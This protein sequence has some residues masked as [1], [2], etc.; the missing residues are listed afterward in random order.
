MGLVRVTDPAP[1]VPWPRTAVVPVERPVFACQ[2]RQLGSWRLPV[3]AGEGLVR[4][5]CLEREAGQPV[6]GD[7]QA[8]ALVFRPVIDIDGGTVRRGIVRGRDGAM[9]GCGRF[10]ARL[11]LK[12][13]RGGGQRPDR[14]P[15]L[16]V[17]LVDASRLSSSS[18]MR[19]SSS[20]SSFDSE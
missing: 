5:I 3:L 16:V 6:L 8:H 9:E 4:R 19:P 20:S 7:E 15:R 11:Q 17:Q 12:E 18:K 2:G 1:L 13:W 10:R 14:R